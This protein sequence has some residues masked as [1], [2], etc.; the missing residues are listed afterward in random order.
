MTT[1][2]MIPPGMR[3]GGALGQLDEELGYGPSPLPITEIP[4]DLLPRFIQGGMQRAGM[5]GGAGGG[6]LSQLI[7]DVHSIA[8][9]LRL[10]RGLL[11]RV[12]TLTSTPQEI[13][14]CQ[15]MGGRGYLIL[16]PAGAT[17]LT[18]TGTL[19]SS[20]TLVGATTLTSGS[21]G[22]ANYDTLRFWVEATFVAGVGPVT[23][24]WQTRNPV[25]GTYITSQTVFNLAATGNAYASIGALGVDTD[26]QMLV[27][28]PAGTTITFSV[29]YC[30]K[31][32]LEGTSA[33]AS[34]TI[35]IGGPGVTSQAGYPILNGKEKQF[36]L[37]ENVSLWGVTSGASLDVNIFEL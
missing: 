24:D 4:G 1:R 37:R 5:P 13:I 14:N 6:D 17:G 26:G 32:G 35:F 15:D 11:G 22:V 36:Y 10:E 18:T 20:Q 19:I 33:G 8:G 34:Q 29:G 31:D 27:T 16:N 21:L 28:V 23:F 7:Y 2:K 9:V 12:V 25:T 3:R 30:L